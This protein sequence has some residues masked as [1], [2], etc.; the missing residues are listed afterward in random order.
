MKEWNMKFKLVEKENHNAVHGIFCTRES[1]V[2]HLAE[3]VPTY[4]AKGYF[5]DK[6]LNVKDFKI[7]PDITSK[8][9]A[10]KLLSYANE[11]SSLVNR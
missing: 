9:V 4:I 7:I 5:A 6:T 3:T 10:K 11:C 8:D 1:A 2:R